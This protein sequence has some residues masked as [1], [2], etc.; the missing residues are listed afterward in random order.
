MLKLLDAG[1][2]DYVVKPFTE[3]ELVGARQETR[4]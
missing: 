1:V 4:C 3:R 2:R